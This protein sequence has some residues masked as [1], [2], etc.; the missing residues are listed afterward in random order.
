M[1]TIPNT[2]LNESVLVWDIQRFG[3]TDFI[4]GGYVKGMKIVPNSW[5]VC[6]R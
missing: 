2:L 4:F 5:T 3:L 1:Q 6:V